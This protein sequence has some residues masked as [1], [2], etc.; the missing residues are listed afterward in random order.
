M[1]QEAQSQAFALAGP[2]DD[3]GDVRHDKR[4]AFA[5]GH[6]AQVG[7]QRGEGIVGN[8]RLGG[9]HG[10]EQGRF[11]CVG[12][13]HQTYVGQQFQFQ[14]DG[15]FLHRLA[16]LCEARCLSRSGAEVPVAQ[17]AASAFQQND[18]LPVLGDVA[19]VFAR[20]GVVGHG[21]AGHFY[22]L[23]LAILAEAAVLRAAFAVSGQHVS[24]VL[25]V[26]QRPV[27]AVAAQDDVA[28]ASAVA[29]VGSALGHV[30][31]AVHV[32]GTPAAL[33]RAAVY[34]HVVNEV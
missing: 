33:A 17:S 22:H 3:A 30:L 14:D 27:V 13:A 19:Q 10:G 6:D 8:L 26:Q 12:E 31:G 24:L 34:L 4:F 18:L 7:L 28:A 1:A 23:V 9:R 29:A 11:A 16:W 5:V 32:C 25:E 21:A 15:H 2:L 20:L